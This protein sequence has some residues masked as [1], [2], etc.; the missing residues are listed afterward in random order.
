MS[1]KKQIKTQHQHLAELRD[2]PAEVATAIQANCTTGIIMDEIHRFTGSSPAMPGIDGDWA[3]V[4]LDKA[5]RW[6]K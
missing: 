5:R 2:A 3:G 4:V 1:I 6:A